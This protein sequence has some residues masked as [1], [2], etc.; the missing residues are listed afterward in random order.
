MTVQY[1][2]DNSVCNICTLMNSL[3][4]SKYCVV[5]FKAYELLFYI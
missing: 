5:Y 3:E 1:I 2:T 4:C